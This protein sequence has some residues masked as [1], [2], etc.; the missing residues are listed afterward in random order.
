MFTLPISRGRKQTSNFLL[1]VG[2]LK[3]K[4]K[5]L[6][7]MALFMAMVCFW[8]VGTSTAIVPIEPLSV[9]THTVTLS[10][11]GTSAA[12]T[13]T[14]NGA[15]GTTKIDNCTVTLWDNNGTTIARWANQ[16]ATGSS[17][18]FS[19]TASPVVRGRTYTLIFTA[20][21]HRNGTATQ[22]NGYITRTFN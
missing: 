17:L 2:K 5:I 20:T 1:K 19:R 13:V 16:S 3:M 7:L 22:V 4:R 11:S 6:K 15:A 12:C 21:V 9:N 14:I 10:F 18:R 8:S